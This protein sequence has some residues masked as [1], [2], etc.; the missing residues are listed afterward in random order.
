MNE[1]QDIFA[2]LQKAT[3]KVDIINES[4]NELSKSMMHEVIDELPEELEHDERGEFLI[5]EVDK[6]IDAIPP[7]I[8]NDFVMKEILRAE[9]RLAAYQTMLVFRFA[10][11]AHTE[12]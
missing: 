5:K 11:E 12:A 10:D 3:E 9:V 8:A 4:M 7:F 1:A 6:K 2:R